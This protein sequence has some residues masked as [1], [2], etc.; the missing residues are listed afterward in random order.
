MGLFD[1]FAGKKKEEKNQT[2][3]GTTLR[4]DDEKENTPAPIQEKGGT[5]LREPIDEPAPTLKKKPGAKPIPGEKSRELSALE[6]ADRKE[7]DVKSLPVRQPG[8]VIL[9]TY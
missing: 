8:D 3:D 2:G 5:I 9:D 1:K 4:K 7:W 6:I